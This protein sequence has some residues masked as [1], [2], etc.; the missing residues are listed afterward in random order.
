[1]KQAL[2]RAISKAWP[3]AGGP[4]LRALMYHSVGGVF[5]DPY[6]TSI[7]PALFT[8]H[9]DALKGRDSLLLTFDD[10]YADTLTVAAPILLERRIPFTVFVTPAHLD[11]SPLYLT[12]AQLK[13]LAKTARIGAHG[14][15]HRPL[16]GLSDEDLAAEL[17]VSRKRLE[18]LIGRPVTTM[19]YPHGK[20]DA[21]VRQAVAKAGYETAWCSRYGLNGPDV[22]P[23]L[24]R[25]TEIT[26][27]DTV[28]DLSLKVTG[29]WDWFA[30]RQMLE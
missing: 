13:E 17:A 7:E 1:M 26:R 5:D 10:G 28:D 4:G 23:L 8:A 12:S 18:D 14:L 20:V 25:R 24:K 27:W 16:T 30:L 2:Y 3:R 6:G 11:S 15:T 29:K 21:R 9:A 19:S 22:D